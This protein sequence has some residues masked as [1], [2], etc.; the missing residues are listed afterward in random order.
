MRKIR[1]VLRLKFDCG[2][3]DRQIAKSVGI[4]RSSVGEYV[5]RFQ[6]AGLVWPLSSALPDPE[7]EACLFPAPVVVPG[8]RR[9]LPDW[10][11]VHQEL[12][13]KGVTLLLLWQEYKAA[14]PEGLQYSRFCDLYQVWRGQRDLVMRQTHRAGEK[15]FVDFCG[16]TVAVTDRETGEIRP[17]QIFVAVLG[18]SNY[19]YAE[20]VASQGLSDWIGAH[21]RAFAF[22]QGVPEVLVP[23]NLASGVTKACRYE[24]DL[25]ASYA[26]MAAH[27]GVAV[28]PAR[29][30]KPRDKAKVEAGVLLVERWVLARLRHQ[31]F[32]SLT[33][34]NQAIRA[35]VEALN[36]RPFKKLPG[37]RLQAFESLDRPA[38]KPLPAVP[39][40]FAHW[41][42]AKVHVDYHV[43]VDGHYYSVPHALVGRKVD[44]RYTETTVEVFHHGQRVAAHPKVDRRGRH[45]TVDSHRPPHH[46]FAQWSPQRLI[47]WA[48][49]SGPA[50]AQLIEA[51]LATRRHPEQGYRSCLGILRLGERF[52]QARLEAAC[53]RALA[54]KALSY[55]S[56]ESIL[57]HGLDAQPVTP[58]EPAQSLPHANLRGP[59]YFH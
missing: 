55:R 17:A 58:T 16:Q 50:T 37:C 51:I 8:Q 12:Q 42:Q 56:V 25:N 2:L 18:A 26:E 44:L 20:A 27:Y 59:E 53:Q 4:A 5:R 36:R 13:R 47:H 11:T 41:K 49:K 43:E 15:L 21:V 19:T 34:L 46:R 29:V 14:H 32:G 48:E 1:D 57:A 28:V 38:L 22:F 3:P 7:L 10:P 54:I 9:P 35:L 33:A 6:A 52:G 40:E 45:S 30:R 24:P 23:D 31:V 39:Y